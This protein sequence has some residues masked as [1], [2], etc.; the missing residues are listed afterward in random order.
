MVDPVSALHGHD[1]EWLD[2]RDAKAAVTFREVTDFRLLQLAAWPATVSD[3]GAAG[4]LALGLPEASGPGRAVIS[5]QG[6]MLRT[7]PLKWWLISK[8][9][10][11]FSQVDVQ[12][13]LGCLLDLS[14]S[15]AWLQIGGERAA[16]LL[17]H[18]VAI[19]LRRDRFG[20]GAVAATSF[21]HVGVTLWREEN[22]FNLFL[23][24]S[25]AVSLWEL[26]RDSA[27]Q[28]SSAG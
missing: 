3:V 7:E 21:H 25:Y 23:P 16:E 2:G 5:D 4:A 18:F 10:R 17:N 20:P 26:L 8:D 15:K 9:S 22:A 12:A 27:V 11:E 19:D 24:R 13:E 28:Y 1:Q 14:H 6:A